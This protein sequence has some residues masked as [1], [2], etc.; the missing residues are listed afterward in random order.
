MNSILRRFL[1]AFPAIF[2]VGSS[3]LTVS[4]M[5]TNGTEPPFAGVVAAATPEAA[6]AGIEILE[7]GGNAVDAA[8]A[9]SFALA[10][11]EP[12]GSGLGGQSFFIVHPHRGAPLAI[13]GTSFSPRGTPLRATA[14][15]ITGHRATTVPSTVRVLD[16]A[17]KHYGSGRITWARLLTPAIR[18]ADAGFVIGPFRHRSFVKYAAQLRASPSAAKLFL[19]PDGSVPAVGSVFRQ[20]VL[21]RTLRRLAQAGANDFYR[22][23]IAKEIASD[24]AA[25]NGWVTLED[26]AHVPPPAILPALKSTY[27]GW[28]VYSLPPP[29]GGWAVL[30]ILNILEHAPPSDLAAEGSRRTIWLVEALRIGHRHRRADPLKDLIHYQ[31]EVA[32]RLSKETAKKLSQLFKHPGSGETTHFSVVDGTGMAVGVT[33]SI[34]SYF[35]AR[36][37]SP[38]LG[39]LY[40]DYMKE[41]ELNQP[42]NPHAW[43]P[44]AMPYSS[45]SATVL[46]RN[47]EVGLVLGS[48]GSARIISAVVQVI[49]HWV[50]VGQGVDAAVAAP[51]VHVVPDDKLYIESTSVPAALLA[52]LERR[53]FKLVNPQSGLSDGS[54]DPYFG[55]VHAIAKEASGWRGA[56]DPRRDG[57]V[58]YAKNLREGQ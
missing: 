3:A 4:W 15:D 29:A 31:P 57:S 30:Q 54:L 25:N 33:Q 1:F 44:R 41:F 24:M 35:G 56:A 42:D 55:G 49:T 9:V 27:R 13:N 19:H 10:V 23:Q 11:T 28:D 2:L 36:V 48:P 46:S 20:P 6:A 16:Y 38:R 47:G 45:M 39:F 43:R 26:L 8:V 58:A 40:N 7:A 32:D 21:A 22:G 37:A 18:Y 53:G 51:R 52:E 17:W 50:D 34:N 5:T 12:A 14:K